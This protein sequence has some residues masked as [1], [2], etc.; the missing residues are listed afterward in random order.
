MCLFTT[1]TYI[2]GCPIKVSEFVEH[3]E[4]K[5]GEHQT[6][7]T[8][9]GGKV[10]KTTLFPCKDTPCQNMYSKSIVMKN[11]LCVKC[12]VEEN[13][14]SF[15]Y[16]EGSEDD[17]ED[18]SDDEMDV[19]E[20]QDKS[21]EGQ[22]VDDEEK[23]RVAEGKWLNLAPEARKPLPLRMQK[24]ETEGAAGKNETKKDQGEFLRLL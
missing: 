12:T 18:D 8:S 2:C 21:S 16:A 15:L 23:L 11:W 13:E 6:E 9:T 4:Y 10:C 17:S 1:E 20:E 19:D 22:K 3:P 14:K 5:N 7:S 24:K